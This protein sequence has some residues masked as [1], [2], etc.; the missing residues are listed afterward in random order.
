MFDVRSSN[1][2]PRTSNIER[3]LSL[4]L[5]CEG[6]E[7]KPLLCRLDAVFGQFHSLHQQ[8]YLLQ[9]G[10][11]AQEGQSM[12]VPWSQFNPLSQ[13]ILMAYPGYRWAQ[14]IAPL[15]VRMRD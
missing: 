14:T 2:E 4:A 1:L 7:L 12:M 9:I 5:P 8:R 11:I 10:H 3:H 13:L 6:R 15:R